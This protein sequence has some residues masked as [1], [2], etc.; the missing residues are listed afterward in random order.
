MV[1]FKICDQI[2][3]IELRQLKAKYVVGAEHR[4]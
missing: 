3:A 2:T 4:N 1:L